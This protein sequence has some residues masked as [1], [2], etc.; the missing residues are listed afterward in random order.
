MAVDP[1][2]YEIA[3]SELL[4][5]FS[6]PV[7]K[8]SLPFDMA[9]IADAILKRAFKDEGVQHSNQ[10]GWQSGGAGHEYE[11]MDDVPPQFLDY[12]DI[13]EMQ[14]IINFI[15]SFLVPESKGQHFTKRWNVSAW[16]NVNRPGTDKNEWHTH[17][18]AFWSCVFWVKMPDDM[19]GGELII[20][21]PRGH[22]PIQAHPYM[23][24]DIEA[25][26]SAGAV[27]AFVPEV[28]KLVAFPGW[29]P[30]DVRPFSGSCERVSVALNFSPIM[31]Q[32]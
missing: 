32:K 20:H 24:I 11:S 15:G 31:L 16:A 21:D 26:Q 10:G 14:E 6:T 9:P 27:E 12:E 28:G 22:L 8:C 4:L 19:S 13:P 5:A 25:C 1:G 17:P 18:G 3:D 7:L 30:H 23:Q 2:N 29:V